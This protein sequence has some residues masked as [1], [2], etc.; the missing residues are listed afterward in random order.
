[1]VPFLLCPAFALKGIEYDQVP[2]NLIKD[3][4]QQVQTHLFFY[5]SKKLLHYSTD[6]IYTIVVSPD[7]VIAMT[8]N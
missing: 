3:G 2:V 4:G 7:A 1:M 5:V 8:K 6:M